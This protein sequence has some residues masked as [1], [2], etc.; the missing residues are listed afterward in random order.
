M[1]YEGLVIKTFAKTALV[2]AQK[3]AECGTCKGCRAGRASLKLRALNTIGAKVGDLV[4]VQTGG[5]KTALNSLAAYALPVIFALIGLFIGKQLGGELLMVLFF[6]VFLAL[7]FVV[8]AVI[9]KFLSKRL[10]FAPKIVK[11]INSV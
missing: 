5:E 9:D 7:S 6:V 3:N 10:D 11:I 2:G 8:L 1:E 4:L